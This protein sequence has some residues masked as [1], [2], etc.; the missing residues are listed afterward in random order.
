MTAAGDEVRGR[1]RQHE[2][3][4]NEQTGLLKVVRTVRVGVREPE[5]GGLL[6]YLGEE[7]AL[8]GLVTDFS[9]KY[10]E[11]LRRELSGRQRNSPTS[12]SA[13]ASAPCA[14]FA[15]WARSARAAPL[16]KARVR[17]R[18]PASRTNGA[19]AASSRRV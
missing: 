6:E 16:Q 7:S 17:R 14:A 8:V 9:R 2:R 13:A 5:F 1:A 11:S 19:L 10:R 3:G 12:G 15:A 4:E 18:E